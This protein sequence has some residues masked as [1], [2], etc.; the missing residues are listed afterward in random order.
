MMMGLALLLLLLPTSWDSMPSLGKFRPENV[1]PTY[2]AMDVLN[3][4][5]FFGPKFHL[6]F[7]RQIEL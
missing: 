3:L 2:A 7:L 1:I 6:V 4:A 5:V